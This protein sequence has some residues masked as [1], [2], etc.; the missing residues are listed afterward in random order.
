MKT[1]SLFRL[2][3]L[4][5]AAL[6]L[7]SS[8]LQATSSPAG[9]LTAESQ[10]ALTPEAVLTHL[11][12]GNSRFVA[13]LS[14]NRDLLAQADATASGQYPAAII[15]SCVDSRVPVEMVFDQG[16]GDVFVARVAG[17]IA[18]TEMLGSM[19]F[20]TAAAGSKLIFVLGHSACG[21]IKGAIDEVELGNLTALLAHLEPVVEA[22]EPLEGHTRSSKH[23][24]YVDQVAEANVRAVIDGILENREVI[25]DLVKNGRVMLAGGLY[26]LESGK[27]TLVE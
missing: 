13:G 2:F 19:E 9:V 14:T 22:T 1:N 26:D 24:A 8:G 17:N 15:L 5:A 25:A 3:A 21:A 11:M 4:S 10:A 12:E 23:A 6:G 20:A 7:A 16:I 27:V 18:S